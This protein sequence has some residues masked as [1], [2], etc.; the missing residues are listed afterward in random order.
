VFTTT[1]SASALVNGTIVTLTGG[2]LPT[3]FTTATNYYVV[4]SSGA[5]FQ[6]SATSGGAAI[7]STSTGSGSVVTAFTSGAGGNGANGCAYAV[8]YFQ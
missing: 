1:G 7:N 3:G 5:T 6:L 4:S 2:S 8:S